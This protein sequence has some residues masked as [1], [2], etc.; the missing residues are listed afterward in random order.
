MAARPANSTIDCW[1]QRTL[2][3]LSTSLILVA[4]AVMSL[5][6]SIKDRHDNPLQPTCGASGKPPLRDWLFGSGISFLLIAFSYIFTSSSPE[7]AGIIFNCITAL[8]STFFFVWAIIGAV[9]LGNHAIDCRTLDPTMWSVGVA[10]V[11]INWLV[12]AFGSYNVYMDATR[13]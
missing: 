5:V 9:T 13:A 10:A 2:F 4:V 3:G 1:T 8:S 11:V 6:V 12:W 7:E